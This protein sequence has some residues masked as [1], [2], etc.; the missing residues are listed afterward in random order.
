MRGTSLPVW[1][2]SACDAV[3]GSYGSLCAFGLWLQRLSL[4]ACIG[5]TRPF[6]FSY[7]SWG[8]GYLANVQEVR[9]A[10]TLFR[11][12]GQGGPAADVGDADAGGAAEEGQKQR[13]K[14]TIAV[15]DTFGEVGP[16]SVTG[17]SLVD[18][19]ARVMEDGGKS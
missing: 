6:R 9:D 5:T 4:H 8:A 3:I 7:R 15:A 13:K 1:D 19:V 18:Q 10:V 16:V 11:E 12:S 2:K 17:L 14:F